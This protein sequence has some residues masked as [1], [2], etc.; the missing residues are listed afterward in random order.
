MNSLKQRISNLPVSAHIILTLVT[1]G[2]FR[3]TN[4]YLDVLYARSQFPVSYPIG[5][6]AFRGEL[7]K[8][9]YQV[10]LDAGT[11]P[12]YWQTQL[13]DYVFIA[14]MF[15]FGLVMPLLVRRLYRPTSFPYR[16]TTLAATLIPLGA[17]CDAIENGWS[18]LM[19]AQ[20]LTFPDWIA[21]V[22]STFAVLKFG[23]VGAGYVCV[24]VGLI[25]AAVA[26][27]ISLARRLP[28]ASSLA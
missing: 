1:F 19:L 28:S 25:V 22:Y 15:T 17:L 12:I 27:I 11:L 5:Q 21:P 3:L 10:M 6:T 7:I 4:V 26:V 16:I 13:F 24:L 14:T 18:F 20:P 8:S 23:A 2:A 9:Y